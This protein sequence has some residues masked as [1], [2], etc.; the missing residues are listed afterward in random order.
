MRLPWVRCQRQAPAEASV[1][2]EARAAWAAQPMLPPQR[3]EIQPVVVVGRAT[4]E[5]EQPRSEPPQDVQTPPQPQSAVE[6]SAAPS[7][8]G[9]GPLLLFPDTS[10]MLTMLGAAQG[11]GMATPFT[12]H[13]LEVL[14]PASARVQDEPPLHQGRECSDHISTCALI[15]TGSIRTQVQH[16]ASSQH[17]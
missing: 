10:A 13:L 14:P 8:G 12:M 16:A 4:A 3:A 5:F 1:L 11:A 6:A 7:G 2:L 15:F 17:G 9:T